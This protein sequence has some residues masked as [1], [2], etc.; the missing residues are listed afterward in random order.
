MIKILQSRPSPSFLFG[1]GADI[2]ADIEADIGAD[3]DVGSS[4]DTEV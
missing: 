4:V 2:G 3:I 1:V